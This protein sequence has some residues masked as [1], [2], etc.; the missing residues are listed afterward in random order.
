M[1]VAVPGLILAVLMYMVI[2]D[3][4]TVTGKTADGAGAKPVR[5]PFKDIFKH[6]NIV[7]GMVGL[8]GAMCGIF[9][10]SANTPMYLSTHLKLGL[11]EM[12]F[13]AS[14]I[15][16]GGFVGQWTLPGLSDFVGRKI[17]AIVGFL[18]A[19]ASLWL[20]IQT[21]AEPVRLFA[22]LFVSAAFSFGLL[23]LIT[24]PIA[25]EAAPLGL[26]ATA[27]GMIIGVGEIF[28]GG[29]APIL[30]GSIAGTYGI[31]YTLYLALGGLLVGAVVSLFLQETAPRRTK[32]ALSELDKLE[33]EIGGVA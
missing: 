10:L 33:N 25:T 26:I 18:G 14:A 32:G 12:G 19:A 21:G 28:G 7:L 29:V 16:F 5:A 1:V 2:R 15:G 6:R 17:M 23:S 24:G 8:L 3:P 20:F 11:Q 13:V 30:A 27:A 31:E 22:L 9:V 4:V